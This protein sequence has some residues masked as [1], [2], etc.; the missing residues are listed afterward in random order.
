MSDSGQI[1]SLDKKIIG[2]LAQVLTR[3]KDTVAARDS[4]RDLMLFNNALQSEMKLL[5]DAADKGASV[6]AKLLDMMGSVKAKY[7]YA[8]SG[9][10]AFSD[11]MERQA[12]TALADAIKDL[13]FY[14]YNK[15]GG[16]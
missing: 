8:M 5:S 16:H 2:E 6:D 15:R 7:N 3:D 1:P 12:L 11:E 9:F 13:M 14:I 10:K 4:L